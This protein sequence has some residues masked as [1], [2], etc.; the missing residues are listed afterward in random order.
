MIREIVLTDFKSYGARNVIGPFHECL[1]L[2]MFPNG[3]DK[4]DIIDALLFVFGKSE[5]DYAQQDNSM[6]R[7]ASGSITPISPT[8][9]VLTISPRAPRWRLSSRRLLT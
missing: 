3:S 7:F 8:D 4:S 5:A 2:I 1:N 6:S 9:L